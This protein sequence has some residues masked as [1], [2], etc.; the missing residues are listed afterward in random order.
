MSEEPRKISTYRNTIYGWRTKNGR[1][2][3]SGR[4]HAYSALGRSLCPRGLRS[5]TSTYGWLQ[6]EDRP[7]KEEACEACWSLPDRGTPVSN[8]KT[9]E[10]R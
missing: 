5:I 2:G 3:R 4:W 8:D 1:S 9:L 7:P 10:T 6:R